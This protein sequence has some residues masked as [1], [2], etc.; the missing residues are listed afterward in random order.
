MFHY[1]S[2]PRFHAVTITTVTE[3]VVQNLQ[4]VAPY[5]ES[6]IRLSNCPRLVY[7]LCWLHWELD[8]IA[9]SAVGDV[10]TD[11]CGEPHV[12]SSEM[13]VI[14]SENFH[15]NIIPT[16]GSRVSFD[17]ERGA[18]KIKWDATNWAPR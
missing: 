4:P 15:P 16:P 10:V 18:L 12:H 3:R 5:T 1:I 11:R 17:L 7:C 6:G 9:I 14:C 2:F 13:M 8:R